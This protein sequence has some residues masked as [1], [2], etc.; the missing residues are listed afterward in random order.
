MASS[1]TA[2]FPRIVY[3]SSGLRITVLSFVFLILLPFYV[4]LGPMLFQRLRHGQWEDTLGLAC[5]GLA[6]TVLMALI[7]V[8]LVQ[9]V[10]MR[11]SVGG[12]TLR[13][14]L[15]AGRG[16][17]PFWRYRSHAIPY[18]QIRLVE[19]RREIY[20]NRLA[21][22]LLKGT[23]IITKDGDKVPLGYVNE[24]NVDPT[25]PYPEIGAEVA[26]RAGIEVIDRGTVQRSVRKKM[27]R[28]ATLESENQPIPQDEIDAINRRHNKTMLAVAALM[29]V[30]MAIGIGRDIMRA[31]SLPGIP[32]AKAGGDAPA[33]KKK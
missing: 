7:F 14:T 24:H 16:P 20:G 3:R 19:T 12:K 21:P 5:L 15:P 10:R 31:P 32:L 6:F 23:R 2:P 28:M 13:M 9:A 4:S 26:R 1:S 17:T 25:F 18:D 29:V 30:V 11:I 33:A 27:L 8:Q 22:V